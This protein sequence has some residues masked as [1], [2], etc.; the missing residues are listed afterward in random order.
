VPF[1]RDDSDDMRQVLLTRTRAFLNMQVS[2]HGGAAQGVLS[3][4][5]ADPGER[6]DPIYRP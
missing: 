6:G 4:A 1:P 5:A 3:R 2:E